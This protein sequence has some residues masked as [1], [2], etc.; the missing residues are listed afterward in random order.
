MGMRF[1]LASS[2]HWNRGAG[3]YLL[4]VRAPFCPSR[5]Q[6]RG[7]GLLPFEPSNQ[8]CEG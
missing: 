1:Y 8:A 4:A 2:P 5:S 6:A 3:P 7:I